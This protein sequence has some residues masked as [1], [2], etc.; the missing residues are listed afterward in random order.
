MMAETVV[1]DGVPSHVSQNVVAS[2]ASGFTHP[3]KEAR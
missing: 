1:R 2:R 3:K